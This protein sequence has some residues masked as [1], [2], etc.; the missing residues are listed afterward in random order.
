MKSTSKDI[1]NHPGV[2][3][4]VILCGIRPAGESNG[5]IGNFVKKVSGHA[6][7]VNPDRKVYR[8]SIASFIL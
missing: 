2:T 1:G 6:N 7:Y 8:L 3:Y 5:R 4:C